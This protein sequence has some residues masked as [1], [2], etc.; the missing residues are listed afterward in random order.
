MC[1]C[2]G[3]C[4]HLAIFQRILIIFCIVIYIFISNQ[5]QFFQLPLGSKDNLLLLLFT[6]F[7]NEIPKMNIIFLSISLL[8]L[9]IY[10]VCAYVCLCL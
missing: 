5:N 1:A 10:F 6:Y 3:L 2:F 9:C 4:S 8:Y 7:K